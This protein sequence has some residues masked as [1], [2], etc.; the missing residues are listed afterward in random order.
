MTI[1]SGAVKWSDIYSVVNG[2][3]HNGS[4]AVSISQF[5]GQQWSD[6]TFVPSK[7]IS[8]GTHFR[9]KSM[10]SGVPPGYPLDSVEIGKGET[11][12]M[13]SANHRKNFYV[14]DSWSRSNVGDY[15][16]FT[17]ANPDSD[18]PSKSDYYLTFYSQVGLT[19]EVYDSKNNLYFEFEDFSYSLY[20]RLGLQA[21][22]TPLE[23]NQEKNLSNYQ[24]G[25]AIARGGI[26]PWL[27]KS[28]RTTPPW[29]E[30]FPGGRYDHINSKNGWMF[31]STNYKSYLLNNR[32]YPAQLGVGYRV[33]RFYFNSDSS[34]NERG[35]RFRVKPYLPDDEGGGGGIEDP[36]KFPPEEG[37]LK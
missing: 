31:P 13:N 33:I 28:T 1:P 29:G 10:P 15:F 11:I 26:V 7:D 35:W 25:S 6:N 16:L 24:T 19:F 36:P 20:D 23:E 21:S 5:V 17:D 30:N 9:G 2:T 12:P 37:P 14:P 34:S 8:I 32:Q 22:N 27:Q 4:T 3:L 18:Y